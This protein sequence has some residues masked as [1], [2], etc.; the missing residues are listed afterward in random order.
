LMER[1]RMSRSTMSTAARP[2]APARA[3]YRGGAKVKPVRPRCLT[4]SYPLHKPLHHS[5]PKPLQRR[6]WCPP[7]GADT[8]API[9]RRTAP[10][11]PGTRCGHKRPRRCLASGSC[12]VS[13]RA[14]RSAARRR[15]R[16]RPGRGAA[17][18]QLAPRSALADLRGRAGGVG[19]LGAG[20]RAVLNMDALVSG[21]LEVPRERFD[22]DGITCS[23][24]ST[25][26]ASRMLRRQQRCRIQSPTSITRA[27]NQ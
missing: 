19:A 9:N 27:T 18:R 8:T 23:L 3:V 10:Y 21:V 4:G 5:L 17:P 16:A 22:S 11:A 6:P 13:V 12:G 26:Q 7:T 1:R 20:G 14:H 2:R 24:G 15:W 25:G